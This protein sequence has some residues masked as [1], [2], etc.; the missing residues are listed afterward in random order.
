ME[1]P[2]PVPKLLIFD[3]DGTF[4]DSRIFHAKTFHRFI[5]QY[6]CPIDFE[7]TRQRMGD[8]VRHILCNVGVTEEQMPNIYQQLTEFC[9]QHIDDLIDEIRV[10]DGIHAALDHAHGCGL[11]CV[12]LT[13]SMD[14][15]AR[16]MLTR[17][18][19]LDRFDQISGADLDS[20]DKI[21]RC[22]AIIRA[23][24]CTPAD[25][26]CIGDAEADIQMANAVG[27]RSCFVKTPVSWYKDERY[28]M[29]VLRPTY[30]ATALDQIPALF[31]N[32]PR[33]V[34]TVT[35]PIDPEALGFCQCHEH[36]LLQK[37]TSWEVNPA[38]CLDDEEK[39]LLE[40][41]DYR[42]AG[43]RS[44]V[45]AQPV[46]CG[47]MADGLERLSIRSGV[48]VVA[49]TGFHKLCFYP[50]GHW[51]FTMGE[52]ELAGLFISELTEGMYLDCDHAPPKKQIPVPAGMIKTAL[53]QGEL[54]PLYEKLF[55]AAARAQTA[56]G[57]PFMVH[58][59]SGSDPLDLFRRLQDWGVPPSSMIFCHMD[60]ACPD[61]AV[62]EALLAQGI[63][64]EFDTIG[65][66]KYHDDAREIEIFQHLIE[67]GF[68]DQLLFSLDTTRARL[69][70][71]TPDGVGLT[72]ILS[73]FLEKMRAAG[74]SEAVIEKISHQNC[75]QALSYS[76]QGLKK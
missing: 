48:S 52:D 49:S 75:Q 45:D 14:C 57:A 66:F 5:N 39:S 28:L 68:E 44:L 59:E 19:L 51:L 54:T 64:L 4:M 71:Y 47:R 31:Y 56:T 43:G 25:T 23:S 53:D 13:N 37:G 35:G 73:V 32:A 33:L 12:L 38:L 7:S 65:R 62:H 74:I 26:I 29:D 50:K 69:K 15:T 30:V 36:L 16:K 24:G 58:I 55:H 11:R 41:R 1:T 8:T 63:Y 17:H 40:L 46:G 27:C 67:R 10:V 42:A 9:T 22:E 34:Q 21:S 2:Y 70:R 3:M 6:I 60:R 61:L 72:Y 20:M 18:Q 76:C